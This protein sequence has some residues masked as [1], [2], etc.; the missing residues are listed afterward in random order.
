[1]NWPSK[2]AALGTHLDL[3]DEN[4]TVAAHVLDV[5]PVTSVILMLGL[6]EMQVMINHVTGRILNLLAK[7]SSHPLQL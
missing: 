3:V 4:P 6:S 5:Q 7:I 1:M 2:S